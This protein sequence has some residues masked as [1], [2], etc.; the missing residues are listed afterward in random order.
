MSG[1][2]SFAVKSRPK[3]ALALLYH[4]PPGS[5]DKF[6]P[7]PENSLPPLPPT[8]SLPNRFMERG[9]E[10]MPLTDGLATTNNVDSKVNTLLEARREV[11]DGGDNLTSPRIE[12]LSEVPHDGAQSTT[13]VNI[14][15]VKSR[16]DVSAKMDLVEATEGGTSVPANK[17]VDA[18]ENA[19]VEMGLVGHE[20]EPV[21]VLDRSGTVL[22]DEVED[23]EEA[24]QVV[25]DKKL[26]IEEF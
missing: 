18:R 16:G 12:E 15:A 3:V 14:D 24:L 9:E 21:N 6:P 11:E 17:I 13:E 19:D 26:T 20:D 1:I 7:R 8:P 25:A 4:V 23:K 2:R 22:E 10:M 5:A